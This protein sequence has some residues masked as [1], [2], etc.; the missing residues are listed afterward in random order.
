M[1]LVHSL[2]FCILSYYLY[3]FIFFNFQ[4]LAKVFNFIF[5]EVTWKLG[6]L[7]LLNFV[8]E[9]KF[10]CKCFFLTFGTFLSKYKFFEVAIFFFLLSTH[11]VNWILFS[12]SSNLVDFCYWWNIFSLFVTVTIKSEKV[13]FSCFLV[14]RNKF[15]Q[16]N[17]A[18]YQSKLCL[19]K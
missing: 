14:K 6:Y 8:Q 18:A 13:S 7:R 11:A 3:F 15:L 19:K 16:H 10:K 2:I 17:Y 12:G 4:L 5:I 9:K 1:H